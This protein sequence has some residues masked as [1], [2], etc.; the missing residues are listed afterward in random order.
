[1][2]EFVTRFHDEHLKHGREW[3]IADEQ[4]VRMFRENVLAKWQH[5]LARHILQDDLSDVKETFEKNKKT[6]TKIDSPRMFD[7]C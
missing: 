2:R 3:D 4:I 6:G 5:M 1:M 7:L